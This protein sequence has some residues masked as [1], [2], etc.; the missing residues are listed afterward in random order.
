MEQFSSFPLIFSTE[1]EKEL[2][3]VHKN[4]VTRVT[5]RFSVQTVVVVHAWEAEAA[6]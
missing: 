1:M 5:F 2:L 4:Q 3:E 6:L